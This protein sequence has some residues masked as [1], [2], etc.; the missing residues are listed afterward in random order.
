M[1]PKWFGNKNIII[2][3]GV[4]WVMKYGWKMW[5]HVL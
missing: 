2:A 3:A 5:S 4:L 1:V